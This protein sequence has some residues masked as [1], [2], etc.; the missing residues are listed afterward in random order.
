MCNRALRPPIGCSC[1]SICPARLP[2]RFACWLAMGHVAMPTPRADTRGNT[3]DLFP[4]R[5]GQ[6]AVCRD[7]SAGAFPCGNQGP[8]PLGHKRDQIVHAHGR[9]A[10]GGGHVPAAFAWEPDLAHGIRHRQISI[11][12]V[13]ESASG[14][15]PGVSRC[16]AHRNR[17]IRKFVDDELVRSA[18]ALS[19]N[20]R[21]ENP[22][23][24][25]VQAKIAAG[26][27][28]PGL[29]LGNW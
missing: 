26:Y 10:V 25:Q 20:Q 16:N 15:V 8:S 2:I 5:Q 1:G 9:H 11:R 18:S 6:S 12:R 28:L 7:D 19:I 3:T 29:T 21:L 13:A 27:L 24:R 22:I 23:L 17:Y 14:C 4:I